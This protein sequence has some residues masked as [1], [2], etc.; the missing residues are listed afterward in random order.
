MNR[1]A[2]TLLLLLPILA[3]CSMKN[4]GIVDPAST[5]DD[6]F[7]DVVYLNGAY[8]TT[9][10]NALNDA[11]N[12]NYLYRLND[13][14]IIE[15][16]FNLGMSDQ[17]YFSAATDGNLIYLTGQPFSIVAVNDAG[18]RVAWSFSHPG[19]TAWDAASIL[20]HPATDSLY[21]ITQQHRDGNTRF[22][23]YRFNGPALDFVLAHTAEL[24][25]S[26]DLLAI[27]ANAA[28]TSLYGIAVDEQN[29]RVI[30]HFNR[31]LG[32]GTREI[33]PDPLAS[34]IC[35]SATGWKL[36]SDDR[37]LIDFIP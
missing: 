3:G 22:R 1:V 30:L 20:F 9:N 37:R 13:D 23:M 26:Y 17:G 31:W 21:L 32:N 12:E 18:E 29:S 34:G 8:Y 24:T 14:G 27:E 28:G 19:F 15:S 11:H 35:L 16:R 7:N 2:I 10:R 36:S 25:G 6:Y 4:E 33:A 5:G